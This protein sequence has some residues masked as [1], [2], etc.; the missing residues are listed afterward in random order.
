MDKLR[1]VIV[2]DIKDQALELKQ[3]LQRD[4]DI[5]NVVNIHPNAVVAISQIEYDNAD[6][7]F[8]D[9]GLGKVPGYEIARSVNNLTSKYPVIVFVTGEFNPGDTKEI[10]Q[11]DCIIADFLLKGFDEERLKLT[12]IR[13]KRVFNIN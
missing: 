11:V 4:F 10:F 1:T 6:L 8:I 5:F 7:Y 2:E 12:E 13:V 9:I 3:Y